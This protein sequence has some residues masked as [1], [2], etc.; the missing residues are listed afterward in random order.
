MYHRFRDTA[1]HRGATRCPTARA[2]T[3]SGRLDEVLSRMVVIVLICIVTT[4][5][6]ESL[7]VIHIPPSSVFAEQLGVAFI[8][9]AI[10]F[11]IG[12]HVT[13]F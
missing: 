4:G 5:F 12:W 7:Y 11:E 10:E 6:Q 1:L 8:M 2:E 13:Q 3:G 9:V